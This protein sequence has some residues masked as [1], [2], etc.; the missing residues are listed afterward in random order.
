MFCSDKDLG[1]HIHECTLIDT[2]VAK[3][4]DEWNGLREEVSKRYAEA[5]KTHKVHREIIQLAEKF[6]TVKEQ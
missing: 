4:R 6:I 5:A 1:K 3:R 2:E